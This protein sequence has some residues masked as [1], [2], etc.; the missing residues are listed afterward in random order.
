VQIGPYSHLRPNTTLSED[1][2]V[3]NFAEIKNSVI[4]PKTKIHHH[5]YTGDTDMG[6]GV[7]IGAGTVTVNYDG[8]RKY[9]TIIEDGVFI[10]CNANLIAPIRV[11]KGAYVAAGSTLNLEVPEGS[12][13]IARERQVNKEGWVARRKQQGR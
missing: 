7:N 1:V 10:G 4:G 5:S 9:R 6:A 8:A 2:L 3:G 12:L 11:G 13:A